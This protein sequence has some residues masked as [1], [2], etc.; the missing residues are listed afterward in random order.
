MAHKLRCPNYEDGLLEIL[1]Y[2]KG[3]AEIT[4]DAFENE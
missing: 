2:V 3:A 4:K 1:E